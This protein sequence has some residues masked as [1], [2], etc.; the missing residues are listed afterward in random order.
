MLDVKSWLETTGLK[1]K[2]ERFLSPPPL[3]YIIFKD[4]ADISGADNKNCI[5]SR[6]I[7]IELYS[8]KVDHVSET[9]IENLL[10]EKAIKFKRD[11]M[12]IDSEKFF[13]TIY[14]FNLVE[15]F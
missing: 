12:W 14:D 3:P 13:E 10:N 9:K 15:K 5:S 4:D 7:N 8:E 11:R 2:E 6:G 1:V